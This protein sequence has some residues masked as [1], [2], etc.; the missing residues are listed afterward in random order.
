MF[1]KEPL[2]SSVTRGK[3]GRL[4]SR[5]EGAETT[6]SHQEDLLRKEKTGEK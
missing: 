3:K 2:P 4:V 1:W 6:S 5:K